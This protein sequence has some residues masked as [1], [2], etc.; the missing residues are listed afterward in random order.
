MT[1]TMWDLV[2]ANEDEG[3]RDLVL[4]FNAYFLFTKFTNHNILLIFCW[5][6]KVIASWAA[7]TKTKPIVHKHLNHE[8]PHTIRSLYVDV[9]FKDVTTADGLKARFLSLC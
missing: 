1:G 6:L 9:L 8:I 3:L 7:I 2:N 4:F 5:M